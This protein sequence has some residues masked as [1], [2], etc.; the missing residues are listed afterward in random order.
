MTAPSSS[1]ATS[2][3]SG[4]SGG[5]GTVTSSKP[6]V[7]LDKGIEILVSF[8]SLTPPDTPVVLLSEELLFQ[9]FS[10]F[11]RVLDCV[12]KNHTRTN[13]NASNSNVGASTSNSSGDNRKYPNSGIKQGG[14]GFVLFAEAGA[15]DRVLNQ[16]ATRKDVELKVEAFPGNC[17]D[18]DMRSVTINS[19]LR[20]TTDNSGIDTD[21]SAV[22]KEETVSQD[23][24][25]TANKVNGSS[26]AVKIDSNINNS[27]RTDDSGT[28]SAFIEGGAVNHRN[29]NCGP[30]SASTD[31]IQQTISVTWQCH[32]SHASEA[33]MR[34]KN[35]QNRQQHQ[36]QHQHQHMHL[37][38][39][40][41][42]Q[43]QQQHIVPFHLQQHGADMP[44]SMMMYQ[45][46]SLVPMGGIGIHPMTALPQQ[47][48]HNPNQT[49]NIHENSQMYV[50][51]FAQNTGQYVSAPAVHYFPPP[52]S[53]PIPAS[54]AAPSVYIGN[55]TAGPGGIPFGNNYQYSLAMNPLAGDVGGYPPAAQTLPGAGQMMISPCLKG[56]SGTPASSATVQKEIPSVVSRFP[57][58]LSDGPHHH[59]PNAQYSNN[60]QAAVHIH[61]GQHPMNYS[62]LSRLPF[63]G[64]PTNATSSPVIMISPSFEHDRGN[65]LFQN[66]NNSNNNPR[67]VGGNAHGGYVYAPYSMQLP[68]HM[69]Q[70]QLQLQE[71]QSSAPVA[72]LMPSVPATGMIFPAPAN[73][74]H[75]QQYFHPSH[76]NNNNFHNYSS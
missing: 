52:L 15:A 40:Q 6:T 39:Q 54:G 66:G 21:L 31:A 10:Q 36:H 56:D 19:S 64:T 57:T 76:H 35:A 28:H 33:A 3:V 1:A 59:A 49:N 55:A 47:P 26:N 34:Q 70:H 20:S 61:N 30:S 48:H 43:Q 32:L 13:H 24:T 37:Q 68:P 27:I 25:D 73:P 18:N 44:P 42:Q 75:Y 46:S 62:H 17:G 38:Q 63:V 53:V 74:Q 14:Y 65:H 72:Y 58:S 23:C 9:F 11:G 22:S 8:H 7:S 41:Q 4:A 50:H 69:I 2:S 60:T 71:Q 67:N 12:V 5:G 51:N 29:A 45:H 16:F